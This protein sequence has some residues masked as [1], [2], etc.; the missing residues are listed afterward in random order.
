MRLDFECVICGRTA[1]ATVPDEETDDQDRP[2]R[3][4]R[5]CE[6]CSMETIWIETSAT[7]R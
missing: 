4:L 6:S 3:T 7:H 5:Q 2:L 1:T